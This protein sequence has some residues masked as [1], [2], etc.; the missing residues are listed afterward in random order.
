MKD[1]QME[2]LES[3]APTI[4]AKRR[5]VFDFIESRSVLGATLF[6]ISLSLSWPVNCVSGRVTELA[7]D[8][9]I[10]DSGLRRVNSYTGKRGI[11]WVAA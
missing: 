9:R 2:S 4:P 5:K 1:T 7:K 11:V 6:E 8:M 3:E 10:K